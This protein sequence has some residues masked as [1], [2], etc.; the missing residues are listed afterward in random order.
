MFLKLSG[1]ATLLV[2]RLNDIESFW[3]YFN[4]VIFLFKILKKI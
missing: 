3:K 4:G 2:V 1:V